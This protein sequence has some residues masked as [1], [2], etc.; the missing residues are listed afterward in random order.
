MDEASPTPPRGRVLTTRQ[1]PLYAAGNFGTSLLPA[2]FVGWAIYFYAPPPGEGL[3]AYVALTAVGVITF[4]GRI[5]DAL[6]DPLVGHWSDRSRSP[7]GRRIPFILWGTPGLVLTFILLW[8]PPQQG[9]T[10]GNAVYLAAVMGAFWF[11]YTVVVAP[12]LSLL[13]EITHVLTERV[14]I[15]AYMA[16]FEVAS[17]L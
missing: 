11:F 1:T 8:F 12:Y 6:A 5:V 9:V 2:V 4:L 14:S 7:H 17:L 13:P 15:S 3:P 16:A 10:L